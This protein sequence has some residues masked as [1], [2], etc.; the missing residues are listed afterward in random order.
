MKLNATRTNR[1]INY[2]LEQ[3]DIRGNIEGHIAII[4]YKGPDGKWIIISKWFA[5]DG[6]F[7]YPGALTNMR[8]TSKAQAQGFID[9]YKTQ[10]AVCA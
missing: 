9:A 8:D 6:V 5:Y 1:V 10:G 7:T 2:V 3:T 4:S